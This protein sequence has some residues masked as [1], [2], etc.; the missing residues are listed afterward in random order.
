[1]K[2]QNVRVLK[3]EVHY[4]RYASIRFCKNLSNKTCDISSR[5][6]LEV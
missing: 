6:F 2:I 1:M 3:I 4:S 5:A